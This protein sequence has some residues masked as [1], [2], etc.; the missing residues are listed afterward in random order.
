VREPAQGLA[1]AVWD[2]VE[3]MELHP[4]VRALL[5]A[6][7]D[8]AE[9]NEPAPAD[10]VSERAAYLDS[11]VRLG[12]AAE[13]VASAV[14]V[15]VPS[16]GVRL[17][18]RLYAPQHAADTE[19]LIVWLHGG[20]WYVGDI[21]TFDR[22]ARA[23]ANASGAKVLLVE[24]RLA[25][26][27]RWPAQVHDADATVRWAR[28]PEGAG[29]LAIDPARVVLGGDSAGG[30][31]AI[32]AARHARSDGLPPLGAL[33]LAYPALDPTLDSDSY[34]EFADGPMLD[35]A[36]MQRCWDL[37][38]DGADPADPDIAPLRAD[39][40]GGLPPVRLAVAE[41]DPVRDDGL[42]YAE[43]LRA[44]GGAVE[45]RVFAGLVH[46]FL[47]WG[48]VVDAAHE[49]IAW[50]ADGAREADSR[51]TSAGTSAP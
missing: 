41:L 20:G 25:P 19:A 11:T 2:S 9:G 28:S 50:L 49:L 37:Y 46:G 29:Q 51:A 14:D 27:H 48:G 32:V 36:S 42:R 10:L 15:V 7:A 44:A 35:R 33:L 43:A 34:R 18:A 1:P 12:G 16:G 5:E 21:P 3:R 22:V 26:E 38:L 23:L 30:Q 8:E 31:L 47:R 24:Y 6:M 4:Q 17:P 40:H 39:D 45:E 13:P